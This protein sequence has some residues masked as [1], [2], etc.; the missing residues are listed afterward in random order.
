MNHQ[1][2]AHPVCGCE[3]D[4]HS[5]SRYCSEIC[6]QDAVRA[7][8]VPPD[9]RAGCRCGHIGCVGAHTGKETRSEARHV[10]KV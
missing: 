1:K 9:K 4:P 5:G 8:G 2:C 10:A 6:E 3:I 7:G